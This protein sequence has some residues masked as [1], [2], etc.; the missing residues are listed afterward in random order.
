MDAIVGVAAKLCE[1]G[2]ARKNAAPVSCIDCEPGTY[3]SEEGSA[4]CQFCP[5][6]FYESTFGSQSCSDCQ[7][8]VKGSNTTGYTA[9]APEEC[10]CAVQLVKHILKRR[11]GITL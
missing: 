10:I 4:V 11:V 5:K 1:A 2:K 7:A 8:V 9:T 6:G 3:S